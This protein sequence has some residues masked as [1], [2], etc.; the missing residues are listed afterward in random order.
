MRLHGRFGKKVGYMRIVVLGGTG[1]LGSKVIRKLVQIGH[2]VLLL[3]RQ[4]SSMKNLD[5]VLDKIDAID[6]DEVDLYTLRRYDVF[7]N[8]ACRYARNGTPDEAVFEANYVVPQKV[9]YK[10]QEANIGR[11]ITIGTGLP[12]AYNAY[13]FSKKQFSDMLKW[14]VKRCNK[15]IKIQVCNIELENFYGEDEPK[16]RFIP[17]T[18]E[19]L[20]RNE[21]I[22]L[23][24]GTQIRDFIYVED[25]IDVIVGLI[26]Y[27]QLPEYMDFPLGTGEGVQIREIIKYLKMLIGSTSELC[28]GAVEGRKNEPDS[29][30]ECSKLNE[31]GFTIKY[32]WKTGM[33]KMI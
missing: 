12:D 30:A 9:F 28:F 5:G 24:E 22:L 21:K 27:E 25:V 32:D 17:G 6:I 15:N 31:F 3:K 29:V 14:Y 4:E 8:A 7:F 2:S 16:N 11:F 26:E 1:Y 18:I 13:S 10:C 33:K 20:K 23:T 19:K